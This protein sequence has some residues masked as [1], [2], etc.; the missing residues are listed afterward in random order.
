MPSDNV[1]ALVRRY[2]AA[3]GAG[4]IDA[5]RDMLAE[6]VASYEPVTGD[7][8]GV[9]HELGACRTWHDAF[10]DVELRVEQIVANEDTVAVYWLLLSTHTGAFMSIPPTGE[11]VRVPGMEINRVVDGKIAEI[12]R[13]SGTM[14]LMTQL[15]A[16]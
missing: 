8:R 11:A 4:D 13:L 15:G 3:W 10:S 16:V 12:W 14:E 7:P 9:E 1:E 2:L 5:M 6:N